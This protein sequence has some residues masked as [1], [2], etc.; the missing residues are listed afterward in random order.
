MTDGDGNGDWGGIFYNNSSA[1]RIQDGVAASLDFRPS[2][3]QIT[4]LD[5]TK[6]GG[7]TLSVSPFATLGNTSPLWHHLML[8]PGVLQ[9]WGGPDGPT[10]QI[11][12]TVA[13]DVPHNLAAIPG[14]TYIR[15]KTLIGTEG[16]DEPSLTSSDHPN[17][18]P[19]KI[20][21]DNNADPTQNTAHTQPLM[22][23]VNGLILCKE[24]IVKTATPPWPD[25]VFNN[26]YKLL[27]ILD[28]EKSIKVNKHLP[29]L[30]SAKEIEGGGVNVVDLEAKLVKKVE[31]L[32]LYVI[33]LKKEINELKNK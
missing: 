11:M 20:N 16:I 6:N 5:K 22:L 33:E 31:E 26:D 30:P 2:G 4:N 14:W 17:W 18:F 15:Y 27:P 32:T 12:N 28:L 21:L 29:D 19:G 1:G 10:F 9:L 24:L 7:L 23:A 8:T 13:A 25:Y 3:T